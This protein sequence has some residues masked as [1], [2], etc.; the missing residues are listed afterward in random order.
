MVYLELVTFSADTAG[1]TRL[2]YQLLHLLQ[3]RRLCNHLTFLIC[4]KGKYRKYTIN[5]FDKLTAVQ[6]KHKH[7]MKEKKTFI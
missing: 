1:Q 2:L 7:E 4:L 3:K 6:Q 5:T